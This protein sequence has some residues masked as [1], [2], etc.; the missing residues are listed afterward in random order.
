MAHIRK[1][2]GNVMTVL[3]HIVMKG[4]YTIGVEVKKGKVV[5]CSR[6]K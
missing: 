3:Y 4:I 6:V 5:Q 2:F 1:S